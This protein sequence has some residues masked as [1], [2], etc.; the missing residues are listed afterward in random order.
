MLGVMI[1]LYYHWSTNSNIP[2]WLSHYLVFLANHH[3]VHWTYALL[4]PRH[5]SHSR[6]VYMARWAFRHG[7]HFHR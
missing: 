1:H 2:M 7:Y 6:F 4:G 5:V 3:R